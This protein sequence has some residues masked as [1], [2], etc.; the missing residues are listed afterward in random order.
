MSTKYDLPSNF[1]STAPPTT[2][3]SPYSINPSDNAIQGKISNGILHKA[4]APPKMDGDE[5]AVM[6]YVYR[7]RIRQIPVNGNPDALIVS[8]G[9]LIKYILK[10]C[11]HTY[12]ISVIC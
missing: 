11:E 5:P 8:N 12:H 6:N 4:F 1:T 10:E 7:N 2:Y 3:E 9:K